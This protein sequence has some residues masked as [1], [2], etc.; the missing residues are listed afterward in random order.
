MATYDATVTKDGRFWLVHVPAIDRYTQVRHLRELDTM[1]AE[2]IELMTGE[3]P[4]AVRYD[5][6]L[7]DEVRAH[8]EAAKQYR[9]KAASA[10]SQAA[11]EVRAAAQALHKAGV[12]LRDIGRILG[13]TY[14]RAHQLVA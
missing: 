10:N 9:A 3:R 8:L 14:Q 1:T 2:L 13:V 6:Q 12:P 7:P 5:I 11:V 4:D